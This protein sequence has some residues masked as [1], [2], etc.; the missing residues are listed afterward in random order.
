M[1]PASTRP[2]TQPGAVQAGG[3]AAHRVQKGVPPGSTAATPHPTQ[4]VM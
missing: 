1:P 2:P 3:F 4:R